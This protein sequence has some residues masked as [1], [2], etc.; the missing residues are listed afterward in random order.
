MNLYNSTVELHRSDDKSRIFRVFPDYPLRVFTPGQ[1]GSLGLLS[2]SGNSKLVKRAYSISSSIIDIESQKLINHR[3]VEYLEFYINRVKKNSKREQITPKLFNLKTGDRIFCGEKIVGHYYIDDI[4]KWK[5][6]ILISSH[7]GESPNNSIVNQLLLKNTKSKI[8]NINVG[9]NWKSLY[10]R[11][12]SL[13][14]KM[15]SNYKFVQFED[16]SHHYDVFTKFFDSINDNP[17]ENSNYGIKLNKDKSLV[18]ICG[19]PLLIGSPIKKGGWE[20]EFPSYGLIN[21]LKNKSFELSTRFK[22]GN[23]I[24]ESYW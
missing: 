6:I 14:E 2:S 4:E 9:K 5:N 10:Q 24:C 13:L 19:D 12:H 23:I 16:D 3:K 7:T 11:E 22:K 8:I 17:N 15:Y 21:V 18:M 20:Y 1:Y